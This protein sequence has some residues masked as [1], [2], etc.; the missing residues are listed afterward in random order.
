MWRGLLVQYSL[1]NLAGGSLSNTG[2]RTA[3]EFCGVLSVTFDSASK[4]VES[5]AGHRYCRVAALLTQ[6]GRN[7]CS[8]LQV[9]WPL[10]VL[11]LINRVPNIKPTA[12]A[13]A[14]MLLWICLSSFNRNV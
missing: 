14:E 1:R 8:V 5:Q 3:T 9:L 6:P 4:L 10:Y 7:I 12:A 13:P 11:L 2:A